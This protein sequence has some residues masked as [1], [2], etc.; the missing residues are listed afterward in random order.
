MQRSKS[1]SA[2]RRGED[3]ESSFKSCMA[4]YGLLRKHGAWSLIRDGL[5]LKTFITE[6]QSSQ[7]DIM[8]PFQVVEKKFLDISWRNCNLRRP[9]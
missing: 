9:G 3:G 2:E 4:P 8:L 1:N 6:Y 7:L 5:T